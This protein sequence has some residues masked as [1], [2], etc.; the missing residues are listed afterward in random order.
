MRHT[1]IPWFAALLCAGGTAL[2]AQDTPDRPVDRRVIHTPRSAALKGFHSLVQDL[3][4]E[5]PEGTLPEGF[6]FDVKD[7]SELKGATLGTSY[8]IHTI[9]PDELLAGG[10]GLGDMIQP[11]GIYNFFILVAGRVVGQVEVGRQEGRWEMTAAGFAPLA[12]E[13]HAVAA[14]EKNFRFV[15]IYQ[16]TSDLVEVGGSE[17]GVRYVPLTSARHSL[18]LS[19]PASRSA[20]GVE[21][22]AGEDLMASLQASVRS[23]LSLVQ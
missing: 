9:H 18:Q 2:C 10:R 21:A 5:T 6:P 13:V 7:L 11:T 17:A 16:A 20:S 8:Q 22:L 14:R 23:N 15:R 12:K 1:L 4:R 19:Q 3:L